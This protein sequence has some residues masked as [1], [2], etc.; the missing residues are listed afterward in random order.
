MPHTQFLLFVTHIW[1]PP[2]LSGH[3]MRQRHQREKAYGNE[4]LHFKNTKSRDIHALP[5]NSGA[6]KSKRAIPAF[7]AS[8][9]VFTFVEEPIRLN[10]C[11]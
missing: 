6:A 5:R 7:C 11:C 4:R 10:G 2:I 8:M 3:F 9:A 1:C